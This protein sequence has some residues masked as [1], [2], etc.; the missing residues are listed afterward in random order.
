MHRQ[1]F[2]N[3]RDKGC[4]EA[5]ENEE[6]NAAMGEGELLVKAKR[7]D[8]EANEEGPI[9][10]KSKV[11]QVR[12]EEDH[13][14]DSG[15]ARYETLLKEEQVRLDSSDS[16]REGE[17]AKLEGGT[18]IKYLSALEVK[19]EEVKDL[20]RKE[21]NSGFKDDLIVLGTKQDILE[22]VRLCQGANYNIAELEYLVPTGAKIL[23]LEACNS[24]DCKLSLSSEGGPNEPD[25]YYSHHSDPRFIT[26]NKQVDIQ[27]MSE[28]RYVLVE[29]GDSQL[30]FEQGDKVPPDLLGGTDGVEAGI[31][32]SKIPS[33]KEQEEIQ[34]KS[35]DEDRT[36]GMKGKVYNLRPKASRK[37]RLLARQTLSD[38]SLND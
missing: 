33:M 4:V 37:N 34:S 29:D 31:E 28:G 32:E 38:S 3:K 21:G 2:K 8:A 9:L 27:E 5:F 35:E 18:G 14:N 6:L 10:G 36:G 12:G 15:K 7:Y 22:D 1:K 25:D 16:P 20:D 13:P 23:G 30:L 26:V 17:K 19:I 11:R 24:G